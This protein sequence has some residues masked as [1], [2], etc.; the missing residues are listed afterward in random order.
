[1]PGLQLLVGRE[2][3][4]KLP[5][6][7]VL[8]GEW[9]HPQLTIAAQQQREQPHAQPAVRVVEDG[10]AVAV[11]RRRHLYA[12]VRGRPSPPAAHTRSIW[13]IAAGYTIRCRN[14]LIAAM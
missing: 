3:G 7:V 14:G 10:P 12:G 1:M 11:G 4:E 9:A 2:V 8:Q 5:R 6:P 13:R